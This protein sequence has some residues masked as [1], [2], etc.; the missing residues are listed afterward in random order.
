MKATDFCFEFLFCAMHLPLVFVRQSFACAKGVAYHL[1]TRAARHIMRISQNSSDFE[2]VRCVQ[3][4]CD[5][6]TDKLMTSGEPSFPDGQVFLIESLSNYRRR[7]IALQP[8]GNFFLPPPCV[9]V[10]D[11]SKPP[12]R[13]PAF[14]KQKCKTMRRDK[15][16]VKSIGPTLLYRV[17][18]PS[19]QV[20]LVNKTK[21]K[22]RRMDPHRHKIFNE[23][24]IATA[25]SG[26]E[27][28]SGSRRTNINSL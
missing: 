10:T 2:F 8:D 26:S 16:V 25:S 4:A 6:R 13:S 5:P 27:T 18:R 12:N 17:Q 3:T 15:D 28:C 14:A 9:R 20:G 21:A 19:R 22:N 24:L 23:I 1:I 7:S 11:Q